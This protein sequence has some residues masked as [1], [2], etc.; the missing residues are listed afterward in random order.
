M[1]DAYM[2]KT[3][4][5]Q[6]SNKNDII[7]WR[8][9]GEETNIYS[10]G[11][12]FEIPANLNCGQYTLY[13]TKTDNTGSATFSKV[14]VVSSDSKREKLKQFVNPVVLKTEKNIETEKNPNFEKVNIFPNPN[15]GRFEIHLEGFT[16]EEKFSIEILNFSGKPVKQYSEV[17]RNDFQID[18][19]DFAKGIYFVKIQAGEKVYLEKVVYR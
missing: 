5:V 4:F 14:I 12:N 7:S 10:N 11:F 17:S 2:Q 8:L 3:Y 13:C 6:N 16:T 9:T 19:S 1:L 18:I 15:N